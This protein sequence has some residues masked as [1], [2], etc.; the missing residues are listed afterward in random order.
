MAG[1]QTP[2]M[3]SAKKNKQQRREEA[4]EKARILR[5]QE[6]KRAK[7]NRIFMIVGAVLLVALLVFAVVKVLT[8]SD[9][10][11][12]G[13]YGGE[14]RALELQNV[15][16][17]DMGIYVG[18]SGKAGETTAD[19]PVVGVWSD[20]M[21][22]G[23][24]RMTINYGSLF[25]DY[26]TKGELNFKIYPVSTLNTA[27][28]RQAAAA[29]YYVATYAPEFTWQFN[30]SLMQLGMQ[31]SQTQA[32]P[33]P[34]DIANA[35]QQLGVPEDVVKDLADTIMSDDW[36]AL[37]DKTNEQF[38]DRGF[39]ATP[40]ITVNDAEDGSWLGENGSVEKLLQNAAAKA[41]N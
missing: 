27:Y 30:D 29:V 3:S 36:L 32:M 8:S 20:M 41:G 39:T 38:R 9:S 21:C 18:A 2:G 22:P 28:S 33:N 1:K 31:A 16:T 10:E 19:I 14:V 23:C 24:Q 7:R 15:D 5:E 34:V 37:S 13:N 25:K 12:A 26:D 11:A 40:T 17:E 6:A 4:R 35:A